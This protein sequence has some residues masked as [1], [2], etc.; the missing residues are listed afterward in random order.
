MA[1]STLRTTLLD[2]SNEETLV[3]WRPEGPGRVEPEVDKNPNPFDFDAHGT[4]DPL[5]LPAEAYVENAK[6][7]ANKDDAEKH[8]GQDSTWVARNGGRVPKTV[9]YVRPCTPLCVRAGMAVRRMELRILA[10]IHKLLVRIVKQ[11]GRGTLGTIAK[12]NHVL[13]FELEEDGKVVAC[14]AVYV[15]HALYHSGPNPALQTFTQATIRTID[16]VELM[17]PQ[18]VE[19]V[20]QRGSNLK[21]MPMAST[22]SC[23]GRYTHL[24]ERQL[25]GR[26]LMPLG[27]MSLPALHAKQPLVAIYSLYSK[28]LR[29]RD[30]GP[31]VD[32][33]GILE[34]HDIRVL[35]SSVREVVVSM[36]PHDDDDDF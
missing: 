26:L 29:W 10:D 34:R 22:P 20:V 25:T 14:V 16:D 32:E 23:V 5:P 11:A 27:E 3:L 33:A 21:I 6:R 36:F 35:A 18:R 8:F 19:H 30:R 9:A 31:G 28:A 13:Q 1:S 2:T 12:L 4:D 24:L 17:W 7:F 15:D